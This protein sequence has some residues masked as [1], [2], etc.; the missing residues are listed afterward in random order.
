MALELMG[1]RGR[2]TRLA[3]DRLSDVV[4]SEP[5]PACVVDGRGVLVVVNQAFIE[6]LGMSSGQPPP[7]AGQRVERQGGEAALTALF[8]QREGRHRVTSRGAAR[9]DADPLW[10]K[11]DFAAST[12]GGSGHEYATAYIEDQTGRV[13]ADSHL[14]ILQYII[15][16][17]GRAKDGQD[18]LSRRDP[19]PV[20]LHRLRLGQVWLPEG[21]TMACSP[22]HYSHGYEVEHI[23]RESMGTRADPGRARSAGP[24]ERA[25]P[26]WPRSS[27]ASSA[28]ACSRSSPP[29]RRPHRAWRGA[30]A[31]R[32]PRGRAASTAPPSS[33]RSAWSSARSSNDGC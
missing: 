6:L 21:D 8:D 7:P 4:R 13:H 29:R 30:R 10:L 22:V 9:T 33:R 23:G 14:R 15:N 5:G 1:R 24:G 32:H 19:G 28:A 3:L 20:P 11:W 27:P 26:R 12:S 25:R 2:R 31:V 18:L 17:A 16:A